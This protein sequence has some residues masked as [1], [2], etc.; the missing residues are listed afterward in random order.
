MHSSGMRTIRLLTVTQ[1]GGGGFCQGGV[2][3]VGCLPLVLGGVSAQGVSASGPGGCV[4][5]GC[6]CLWSWGVSMRQTPPLWTDR[7]LSK[8]NLRKLRS[9][10]VKINNIAGSLS[11]SYFPSSNNFDTI[12]F[13]G[14]THFYFGHFS[15]IKKSF[16]LT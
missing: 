13:R 8:H 6:V 2:C 10:A 4:C 7:H 16:K 15:S 3:P 14:V 1:N 11:T 9:Q 5:P 12:H